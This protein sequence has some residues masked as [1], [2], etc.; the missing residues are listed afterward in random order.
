MLNFSILGE[1]VLI[2]VILGER[3][4]VERL[5]VDSDTIPTDV[6]LRRIHVSVAKFGDHYA[7]LSPS[8]LSL[9]QHVI[10]LIEIIGLQA[11]NSLPGLNK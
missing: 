1:S 11:C 10:V 8:R 7:G 5:K 4:K 9:E 6:F 3:M 2:W